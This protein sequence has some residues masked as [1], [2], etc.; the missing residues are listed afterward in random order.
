M[1]NPDLHRS[2]L[3][4]RSVV[5]CFAV[6][7]CTLTSDDFEPRPLTEPTPSDSR[8]DVVALLPAP[9]EPAAAEAGA[10]GEPQRGGTA[11]SPGST[12]AASAPNVALAPG[13]PTS[14]EG[15]SANVAEAPA[16]DAGPVT[17]AAGGMQDGGASGADCSGA[18][19]VEA[20]P[21]LPANCSDA[22]RN[23]DE[24]G[25]DC[26]GSVCA[27][28]P[29]SYGTPEPLGDPNYAGNS[30]HSPT[31]SPDGLTLLFG[32]RVRGGTEIIAFSTRAAE[33]QPFGLGNFLPG[34][35]NASIGGTPRLASDDLTLYFS[36]ERASGL[37][38]RDLYRAQR[39]TPDSDLDSVTNLAE[40]NSSAADQLPWVGAQ[41]LSMY[42][43][44]DRS[45]NLDLY[46]S[47]RASASDP[48]GA[49]EPLRELNSADAEN[50]ATL[51]SDEREIIFVST[52]RGGF[53]DFFR[54]VRAPGER[55]FRAPEYLDALSTTAEEADPA[56]SPDGTQLYFSSTRDGADS[57]IWRVSRTCP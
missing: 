5:A 2:A 11:G 36:S 22:V 6:V 14:S 17:N 46:R 21:V 7:G 20:E 53:G 56:L 37:G 57:R 25:V 52:R 50:G 41:Q 48:W 23:Q 54:A 39:A 9:S 30:L 3:H 16:Q 1:G 51:T 18:S 24:V 26:G 38:G 4:F 35:V 13:E 27:P 8:A 12:E 47:V 31:L 43:S 34:A 55:A 19:C 40:V 49:P 29:C 42:F 32:L 45:G 10:S 15:S 28:C 33:D 44:S